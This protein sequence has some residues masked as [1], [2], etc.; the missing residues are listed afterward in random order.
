MQT[1]LI[2]FVKVTNTTNPFSKDFNCHIG[3][4]VYIYCG[5]YGKSF[6]YTQTII[7]A[8][9]FKSKS[10]AQE[11]IEKYEADGVSYEIMEF[12]KT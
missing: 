1:N 5:D 3:S 9:M 10:D 4:Y 6:G 8:R 11:A 12:K 2:Y 7:N